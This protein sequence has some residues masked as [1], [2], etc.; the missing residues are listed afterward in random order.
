MC[1]ECKDTSL[2]GLDMLHILGDLALHFRKISIKLDLIVDTQ[3][4]IL[5]YEKNR[6]R[7][8]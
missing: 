5:E 3:K 1:E 8:V 7:K 2:D 6:E 4:K